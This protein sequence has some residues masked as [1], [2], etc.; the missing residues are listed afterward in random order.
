MM[1]APSSRIGAK[2]ADRGPI[3]TRFGTLSLSQ[4]FSQFP[5]LNFD[6]G[7]DAAISIPNVP[8]GAQG[9]TVHIHGMELLG[10]GASLAV[11]EGSELSVNV[12]TDFATKHMTV[13]QIAV[14]A[15]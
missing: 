15:R 8:A 13:L 2:I 7:G 12:W 11:D 1:I 14:K 5:P 10:G 6:P 4:P 3:A 9:A